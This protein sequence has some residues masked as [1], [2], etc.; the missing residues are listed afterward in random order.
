MVVY[1]CPHTSHLSAFSSPSDVVATDCSGKLSQLEYSITFAN[2]GNPTFAAPFSA[3][4]Q[5]LS[6]ECQFLLTRFLGLLIMY[7]VFTCVY[8]VLFALQVWGMHK[9]YRVRA[10]HPVRHTAHQYAALT[11][12]RV[13]A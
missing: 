11:D 9:L 13:V 1:A 5:G 12:P 4:E 10:L 6:C 8:I 3:D 2:P 7:L